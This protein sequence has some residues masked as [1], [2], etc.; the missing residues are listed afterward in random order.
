MEAGQEIRKSSL[1]MLPTVR[2]KIRLKGQLA[3]HHSPSG[4][5]D[6]VHCVV[7]GTGITG[8]LSLAENLLNMVFEESSFRRRRTQLA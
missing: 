2:I 6:T 1:T 5:F 8:A 4:F 7:G 3:S